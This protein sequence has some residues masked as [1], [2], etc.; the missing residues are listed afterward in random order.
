MNQTFIPEGSGPVAVLLIESIYLIQ[1]MGLLRDNLEDFSTGDT[2]P[3]TSAQKQPGFSHSLLCLLIQWHE[4]TC[5]GAHQ[6]NIIIIGSPGRS[7]PP[8]G[9]KTSR[10]AESNIIRMRSKSLADH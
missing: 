5:S 9:T 7:M 6:F 4:S 2:L 10:P 1:D 3:F 8:L